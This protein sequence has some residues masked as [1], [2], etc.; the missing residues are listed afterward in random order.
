[1]PTS[2]EISVKSLNSETPKVTRCRFEE[3][4]LQKEDTQFQLEEQARVAQLKHQQ[5]LNA[6]Q[7]ELE[8]KLKVRQHIDMPNLL[9][10]Y[11]IYLYCCG[12]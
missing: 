2:G 12:I 7:H 6:K 3:L 10:Y 11:Q 8:R 1:M 9:E 5:D 4:K